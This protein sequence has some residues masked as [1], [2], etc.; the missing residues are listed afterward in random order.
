M[1]EMLTSAG[2]ISLLT[3]T[4]LEIIL[5]I[6][7]IIFISI[8]A[9]KLPE[10][11]RGKARSIGI[12]LAL[13]VRILL[14]LGI[15]WIIG[16]QE[17]L[18]ELGF[19]EIFGL[20]PNLSG[21][22]LILL[23]GGLFLMGKSVAEI[24]DKIEGEHHDSPKAKVNSLGKAIIQIVLIDIV[25]SFDSILTAVGLVKNVAIMIT[26]VIISLSVMLFF[27]KA[28][29]DFVEKN[30]TLKMLALSFL[31]LIGFLLVVEGFGEH[32]PKGYVYF[33]MAFAFIVEMINMRVRKKTIR[34]ELLDE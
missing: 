27:A 13:G 29:G 12:L 2:L 25:F 3:L 14:L 34:Q 15:T 9:G 7:N 11:Q 22:D 8:V 26:A 30:P 17:P 10:S 16:L 31:V 33:A 6:D 5:G 21:K 20:D 28:I 18:I 1:S 24:H 4:L 23:I 19:L 32:I